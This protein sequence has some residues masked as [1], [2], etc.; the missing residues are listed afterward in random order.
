MK[1]IELLYWTLALII[2]PVTNMVILVF[3][4]VRRKYLRG[5]YLLMILLD[6]AIAVSLGSIGYQLIDYISMIYIAFI[7]IFIFME[8][9][10]V[11]TKKPWKW[12]RI[13][14]IKISKRKRKRKNT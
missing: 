8:I 13:V 14:K 9:R 3:T 6:T 7:F 5:T 4:L 10:S 11:Y 2:G 12:W 1:N